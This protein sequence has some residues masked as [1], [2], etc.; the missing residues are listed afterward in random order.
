VKISL[1]LLLAGLACASSSNAQDPVAESPDI[2]T[3]LFEDADI[4]VMAVNIKPGERDQPHS[5]S[6]Y[7]VYILEGGRLRIHLAGGAAYESTL[8]T[9]QTVLLEPVDQ[10]WGE[11]IGEKVV[12]IVA[13]EFK[14]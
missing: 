6:R 14:H 2:Y 5:H 1:I 12:R 10:H 8:E 11:N 3:V 7:M 9:G 4:R 13:I